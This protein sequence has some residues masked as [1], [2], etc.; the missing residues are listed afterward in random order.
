[1]KIKLPLK[2]QLTKVYQGLHASPTLSAK[3]KE[4]NRTQSILK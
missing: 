2:L 3:I 4:F 1:M